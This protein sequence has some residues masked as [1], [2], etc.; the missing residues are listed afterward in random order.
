MICAFM[1]L[2]GNIFSQVVNL[3]KDVFDKERTE[4]EKTGSFGLGFNKVTQQIRLWSLNANANFIYFTPK[5]FYAT[6]GALNIIRFEGRDAISDGF[7]QFRINL[8]HRKLFVSEPFMH[9]QYDGNRGLRFR[10]QLGQGG[11]FHLVKVQVFN[12]AVGTGLMYE[13]ENW[14]RRVSDT[15]TVNYDLHS[16]KTSS[17]INTIFKIGKNVDANFFLIHQAPVRDFRTRSRFLGDFS[18]AFKISEHFA[19]NTRLVLTDD[20]VP[21]L[22]QT[23]AGIRKF[24][25]TWSQGVSVRF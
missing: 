23:Q 24:I 18:F 4:N 13:F 5:N 15:L 19:Y 2:S 16:I 9:M 17:Y 7:L 10:G 21:E 22:M 11:R 1:F 3:E 12:L 14:R 6:S 25:Y 20:S 8:N